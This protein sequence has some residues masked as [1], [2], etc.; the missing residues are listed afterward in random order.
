[1]RERLTEL[2]DRIEAGIERL[3]GE[4]GAMSATQRG[5]RPTEDAWSANEVAHHLLKVQ[6]MSLSAIEEWRDKPAR[7]RSLKQ[8][9]ARVAVAAVLRFGIRVRNPAPPTSPDREITFEELE[10]SWAAERARVKR[11]LD[12]LDDAALAKAGM[13]HPVAGPL[14]VGES[15]DFVACHLEHHLRQL[16]RLRSDPRFPA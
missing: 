12:S 9:I 11:L 8:K 10:P 4:M 5:Y 15:L 14:N 1:M 3:L 2:G 6:Q 7:P 13:K 16:E